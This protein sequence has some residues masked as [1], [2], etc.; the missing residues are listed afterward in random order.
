MTPHAQRYTKTLLSDIATPVSLFA[1]LSASSE[2]AFLLESNDGDSRLARYSFI[3]VDPAKTAQIDG[4]HVTIHDRRLDREQVIPSNEPMAVLADLMAEYRKS[5]PNSDELL[6][7]VP[8]TGGLFGYMGF[9]LTECFE[10]IPRQQTDVL[11]VPDGIF[12]L[13]DTLAIFDHLYHR[14]TLIA[15]DKATLERLEKSI[16]EPDPLKPLVFGAGDTKLGSDETIFKNVS[17]SLGQEAYLKVVD[18]AK[19]AI[20]IGEI[21]QI[22]PAQRY[23]LPV[24][25][26]PEDIYRYLKAVNPSP[27]GYILKFPELSYVGSSPETYV[28]VKNAEVTL[29]A[30]AGTRPRGV[31]DEEDTRLM[32]ELR[33]NEKELAEHRMLVDLGRNDLGRVCVP[34][35]VMVGEIATV[36]KYTHVM[37]LATEVYGILRG[38]KS[39]FDM[40]RSCFPRGTVSGAPKI[41]AM[42]LLSKLEPEQRGIYSGM[43]GY[44]DDQGN[45]DSA[46]AIRS[47]LVKAGRAHVHAGAGVVYDSDPEMEYQETRNKAKSVLRAIQLAENAVGVLS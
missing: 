10:N 25:A 3:G 7:L 34:G 26:S 41:R 43:V 18:T 23:S 20:R 21:F 42:E 35:S 44:F 19:E 16:N 4:H 46:I 22:V 2:Y 39:P 47:V 5:H 37:H 38:E 8:F 27:Y 45:M 1:R 9:G 15:P 32:D 13:Y 17:E 40:A 36:T 11:S 14:L 31:D 30:L 29:R 24:S 33:N 6:S 12:G 28:S